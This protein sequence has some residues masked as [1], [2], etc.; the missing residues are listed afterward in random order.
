M[1]PNARAPGVLTLRK[2]QVIG[3]GSV[4]SCAIVGV[5]TGRRRD[6]GWLRSDDPA[7]DDDGA[8]I[9]PG[10]KYQVWVDR[11]SGSVYLRGIRP[12]VPQRGIS[13]RGQS[14]L[15]H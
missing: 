14:R 6:G 3:P 15:H 9:A 1:D 7:P 8:G 5:V 10:K 13:S 2:V 11:R 4:I 12:S